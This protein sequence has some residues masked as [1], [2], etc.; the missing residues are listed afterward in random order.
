MLHAFL[1]ALDSYP[2]LAV[3]SASLF[4]ASL[5]GSTLLI[6]RYQPLQGITAVQAMDYLESIQSPTFKFQFVAL[7]FSIPHALHLWGLLVF[8]ANCISMLVTYFGT[9]FAAGI[10]FMAL[11]ALLV[12][13]WTT[14]ERFN[15]SVTRI[16]AKFSRDQEECDGSI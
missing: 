5:L 7:V 13:Q 14:S 15:L 2:T 10:S 3:A 6:H 12:F 16:C 8:F 1:L 9:G 4:G 11:L